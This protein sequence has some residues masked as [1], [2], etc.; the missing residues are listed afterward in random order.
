VFPDRV[1]YPDLARHMPAINRRVP[2]E[3]LEPFLA[4]AGVTGTIC[5]QAT[6]DQAETAVLLE[7]ARRVEWIRGVVGWVPL[8]D[9]DATRGSLARFDDPALVGVRH[10]LHREPAVDWLTTPAVLDALALLAQRGLVY[11]L[12]ALGKGYLENA[13]VVIERVPDLV[14]VIDHLGGPNVRGERWEPWASL[15][16]DAAQHERCVVKLSGLD[17]VDGST[18]GYRRYVEHVLAQF[19]PD[20]V[21]WASNWP[22]TRLGAGYQEL[23]DDAVALLPALEADERAAIFGGNARRVYG[24]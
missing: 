2:P 16:A 5:V 7:V 6:N 23:L 13:P 24:V 11:E 12:L 4:A 10:L 19:G 9:P 21:L 18:E 17:P 15:M 22:A 14:L 3:E 8:H 20:R 1:A